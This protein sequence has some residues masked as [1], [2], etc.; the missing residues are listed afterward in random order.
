MAEAAAATALPSSGRAAPK[1]AV[2]ATAWPAAP[3]P[4]EPPQPPP[5]AAAAPPPAPAA[6]APGRDGTAVGG[7]VGSG[8]R[9]RR[10]ATAPGTPTGIQPRGGPEAPA[11]PAPLLAG[12]HGPAG[13]GG[14]ARAPAAPGCD[15][16]SALVQAL[17]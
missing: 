10:A 7:R 2:Q 1:S 17:A 9:H 4:P 14:S 8:R 3:K 11:Q 15:V 13:G 6:G 5:P 12:S 16:P